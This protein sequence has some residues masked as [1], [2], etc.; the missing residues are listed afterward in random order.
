MG[1]VSNDSER[2]FAIIGAA[3]SGKSHYITVLIEEIKRQA[4]RFGWS[5]RASDDETMDLF[6]REFYKPL[7]ENKTTLFKTQNG[8]PKRLVYYLRPLNAKVS[9]KL[10]FYDISGE[11]FTR[12]AFM[13]NET[14]YLRNAR[15]II[16]LVDPLQIPKIRELFLKE[17]N[18]LE[19]LPKEA[20]GVETI[21]QMFTRT[22]NFLK[23]E[24][25][26]SGKIEIPTAVVLTKI[27][28]LR[29]L[30][31]DDAPVFLPSFCRG[32]VSVLDLRRVCEYFWRFVQAF[33]DCKTIAS[34][35]RHFK[36]MAYFGVS[37][38]G[39]NPQK[40]QAL[41]FKPRPIRPLDPFLW[42]LWQNGLIDETE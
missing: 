38:L 19:D 1:Y 31:T 25:Y 37:A 14:R 4:S 11:T 36:R 8:T 3:E 2:T 16:F 33:D 39:Q 35:A 13:E 17:G 29:F 24:S 20:T 42:L 18:S 22:I 6:H 23:P 32:G 7:Y 12:E 15:G 40:T 28:A 5:L 26:A 30:L 21:E 10:S 9:V 27:D 34:N 41:Q